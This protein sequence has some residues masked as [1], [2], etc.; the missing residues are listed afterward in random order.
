MRSPHVPANLWTY[1]DRLDAADVLLALAL[2][3]VVEPAEPYGPSQAFIADKVGKSLDS[4]QRSLARL[5]RAKLITIQKRG[6]SKQNR[7]DLAPLWA[8]AKNSRTSA[9]IPKKRI[10]A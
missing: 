2:L 6:P 7:Y 8:M 9:A 3:D 5:E 1:L 4:V 10:A